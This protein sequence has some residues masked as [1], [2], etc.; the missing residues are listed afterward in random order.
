MR[1]ATVFCV[2]RKPAQTDF[3]PRAP[4]GA[5]LNHPQK[6][7]CNYQISTHAPLAGRDFTFDF[8]LL[9]TI[10]FNPRA[11]C[12]ARL[13]KPLF[14]SALREISTHAPLA[15]RDHPLTTRR[16]GVF[17]FNPRAPCGARPACGGVLKGISIFQPT[18]PLRGATFVP[19]FRRI[20]TCRFQPT[21]PLRGATFDHYD[22]YVASNIST[23]APLAGRDDAIC[24]GKTCSVI[25]THAPLAGRDE[26]ESNAFFVSE[27]FNPRAPCGARQLPCQKQQMQGQFQ[28]TRPLRGATFP[29]GFAGCHY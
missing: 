17:Y 12:G 16:A 8:L 27:D 22:Y 10:H 6:A 25:S 19:L 26:T 20:T 21:R 9:T 23:H 1:G 28:P 13:A 3:N 24:V 14:S 29:R 4:C 7:S 2:R 5:R 11:P 18:R 15:G